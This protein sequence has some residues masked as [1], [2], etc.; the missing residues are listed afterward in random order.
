MHTQ[1]S[2]VI[3]QHDVEKVEKGLFAEHGPFA[4]KGFFHDLALAAHANGGFI[5]ALPDQ[6]S[7]SAALIQELYEYNHYVVKERK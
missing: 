6:G 1:C 4:L 7:S 2:P 3:A 5:G